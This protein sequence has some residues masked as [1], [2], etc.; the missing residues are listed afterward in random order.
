[1][2]ARVQTAAFSALSGLALLLGASTQSFAQDVCVEPGPGYPRGPECLR[3]ARVNPVSGSYCVTPGG[4]AESC[5]EYGTINPPYPGNSGSGSE[6]SRSR[7]SNFGNVG[8]EP[9]Y[10]PIQPQPGQPTQDQPSPIYIS[11][12]GGV[13]RVPME[14]YAYLYAARYMQEHGINR[15][16]SEVSRLLET[17]LAKNLTEDRSYPYGRVFEGTKR[18]LEGFHRCL[19]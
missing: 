15:D 16:A 4:Y 3:Y 18:D 6:H 12:N 2:N 17:C 1:M 7:G 5:R 14:T 9:Y 11:D 8:S 19:L 13:Y 10:P